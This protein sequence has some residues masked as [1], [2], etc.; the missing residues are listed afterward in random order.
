MGHELRCLGRAGG[1]DGAVA[2]GEGEAHGHGQ[3]LQVLRH[4]MQVPGGHHAQRSRNVALVGEEPLVERDALGIDVGAGVAQQAV[5]RLAVGHAGKDL[6]HDGGIGE[7]LGERREE[8][9]RDTGDGEEGAVEADDVL[10]CEE[11]LHRHAHQHG[12]TRRVADRADGAH[13]QCTEQ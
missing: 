6:L 5:H 1:R 4:P 10:R 3:V 2:R 9:A 7:G 13:I 12:R 8:L 11:A